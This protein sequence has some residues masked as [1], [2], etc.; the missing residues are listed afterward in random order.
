MTTKKVD[1][2]LNLYVLAG[3]P[4]CGKTSLIN[5]LRSR[6]YA[7][8]DECAREVID[9]G[10]LVPKTYEFQMEIFRRQVE[11]ENN[12]KPYTFADRCVVEGIAYCR[13]NLNYVPLELGNF[14]YSKRYSLVFLLDRLPFENDGK[15]LEKDDSEALDTHNM[16]VDIYLERNYPLIQVPLF[17][18]GSKEESIRK[19]ADFVLEEVKKYSGG[20]N[21]RYA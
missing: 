20:K 15:R 9:E 14:D 21:G 10:K 8:L 7:V 11:R 16:I 1:K 3:G 17:K 2:N 5:E 12:A 13:K 19:R 4:T 6:G 18:C